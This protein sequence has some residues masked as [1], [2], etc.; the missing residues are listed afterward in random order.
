M[1]GNNPRASVPTRFLG[2]QA[3]RLCR[4]SRPGSA[5]LPIRQPLGRQEEGVGKR[6]KVRDNPVRV[7]TGSKF[8]VYRYLRG[9]IE[10]QPG[11]AGSGNS[12][13]RPAALLGNRRRIG[14]HADH[15]LAPPLDVVEALAGDRHRDLVPE[16]KICSCSAHAPAIGRFSPP[17]DRKVDAKTDRGYNP[18]R[19]R[20]ALP[21]VSAL[22]K[23]LA[24][25]KASRR[26]PRRPDRDGW[27]RRVPHRPRVFRSVP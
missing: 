16:I 2:P 9:Y 11:L 15:R 7:H 21:P 23:A 26:P 17:V 24:P 1:T 4:S 19:I 22:W 14:D 13:D 3:D 20:A 12:T 10:R 18:R 8:V 6:P 25:R 5:R 27:H